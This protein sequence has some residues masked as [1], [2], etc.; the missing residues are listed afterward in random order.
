MVSPC[1]TVTCGVDSEGNHLGIC[2]VKDETS[3]ICICNPGYHINAGAETVCVQDDV[4]V[5]PCETVTCG[6]DSEGNHLGI[7]A[8]KDDTS[9][10]CIC[11]PGYHINAGSETVCVQDD[12]VV[13][14]CASVTC[15]EGVCALKEDNSPICICNTGYHLN[16]G[17]VTVCVADDDHCNDVNCN[18]HGICNN[19]NNQAVCQ[20][21]SGYYATVTEPGNCIEDISATD[22]CEEMTCNGH[23]I[24]L[25]DERKSMPICICENGYIN[26][27]PTECIMPNDVN[28]N[29]MYDIYETASD[30]GR[31]C[32]EKGHRHDCTD[33]CDSFIGYKCSTKCTNN[34][35]CLDGFICRRD[36]RCAAEAFETVWFMEKGV[37]MD[38]I[39]APKGPNCN[40][41]IDWGDGVQD[42]YSTC[43]TNLRHEYKIMGLYHIKIIGRI[44][45]WSCSN[46]D[47]YDNNLCNVFGK[48]KEVV[49]FGPVELS[50]GAF[51]GA[52][53]LTRLS[54]I[55][56]PIIGATNGKISIRKMFYSLS[57]FN[58]DI[59]NWDTS[60]VIDM[61]EAFD[62]AS[63]FNQ[64]IGDWDTSNVE[65]MYYMFANASS[66]NQ[67]IGDWDTSNVNNMTRM[68]AS[69][70]DFNQD[71]N[72]WNTSNVTKMDNMFSQAYSFNQSIN[73]WDTSKVTTMYYMFANAASFNQDL[74]NWDITN[75]TTINNMFR[76]TG[77]TQDTWNIMKASPNWSGVTASQ[78][79]LDSSW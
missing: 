61:S 32:L 64:P 31:D 34:S 1:E 18:G 36:G 51:N 74:S 26:E 33:F 20:C 2:A 44:N 46:L 53:R 47:Q 71:L 63:M 79:G 49:S 73:N 14:P 59:S 66:F 29:H 78:V 45:G 16:E 6:V 38:Q 65:N 23:G 55:D 60:N 19:M 27:S 52:K 25:L 50:E 13:S 54:I 11:N 48:L 24:C 43:P 58:Q 28:H 17:N 76:D 22:P 5:S 41:T 21:E 75:V 72:D 12:V 62:G 8:V 35:Q 68:F 57:Q 56:I 37:T 4:V 39:P 77:M 3:A 40:F 9:A 10:I 30:Q 15:G 7:C 42:S 69:A 70:E 67:P